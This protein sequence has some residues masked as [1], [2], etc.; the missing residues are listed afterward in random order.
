MAELK[1]AAGVMFVSGNQI[2]LT[3]RS[4]SCDYPGTWAFPAGGLEAGESPEEAARR[5][6]RE[7][8]KYEC[9]DLTQLSYS[10]D[11]HNEFT[12]FVSRVEQFT[13]TL[14]SE[15]D[16]FMW[17]DF[18]AYPANLHPGV[19]DLLG[20]NHLQANNSQN[21]ADISELDV[22]RSIASGDLPS[23][24]IYSNMALFAIR[25][26][27]T[28]IA[29]R[30]LDQEYVL[31]LPENYLTKEFLARCNGVP[32]I[33]LHPKKRTLDSKEFK[34]R[35]VGSI[36]LPYIKGDEVWAIARIYDADAVEIMSDPDF[37]VSTSPTVVFRE[38]AN[39]MLQLAD[40][41][42]FLIEGKPGLID[43][44][45]VC[46]LGVWDKGGAAAGVI[47][48][49]A[50]GESIM[51]E[52]ELKAKADAEAKEAEDKKKADEAKV[53]ADAEQPA[54]ARSLADSVAAMGARMDSMEEARKGDKKA[55]K[56]ADGEELP[57]P[58]MTAADK[59]ADEKAEEA[60]KKA[61]AAMSENQALKKRLEM[62]EGN[63]PRDTQAA[64]YGLFATA[65]ARADS[66]YS[67]LGQRAPAPM[68][69]ETLLS[70]K[71][72]LARPLQKHSGAWKDIELTPELPEAVLAMAEETIYADAMVSAHTV[73]AG[74]AE[75]RPIIRTDATGR[76]ITEY[77]GHSPRSW[78]A[79][80]MSEPRLVTQINKDPRKG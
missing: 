7:E 56:K 80:F 41:T 53:K 65:Q 57:A 47:S 48:D 3:K 61:D 10:N 43:H 50:N 9:S 13:P 78:M 60:N 54:W 11:G 1:R 45:A 12:T 36:M 42:P 69:G 39:G 44:V 21:S 17:V 8:L 31:R 27:G 26:T 6:C 70:Y 37:K 52:E 59:K 22:A 34:K 51:T 58:T 16:A 73:D 24:Q 5:E 2:L 29:Y 15:S 64:D 77:A 71:K 19:Q 76:Q 35:I 14:N 25:V 49:S 72:R 46:E 62:L 32:V 74:S 68:S 67:A 55:D 66:V 63:L 40:G 4:L 18:G 75:L 28:G 38:G 20:N 79:P 33:M 30:S 23:P